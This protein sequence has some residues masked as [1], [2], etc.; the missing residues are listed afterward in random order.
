MTATPTSARGQA[1]PGAPR[2]RYQ[3][4]A[5]LLDPPGRAWRRAPARWAKERAGLELWSAQRRIIES[6]RDHTQTAVHSCHEVGK[7]F[8]AAATTCWWIDTHP[9]GEAFVVTT[10]PSDK[11]VKAILWREINK[12]HAR[13][14]LP[15]RT[16]LDEWYVGKEMV[17]FGRKPADHDPTAFQGLHARYVLVILDEACGIPKE[18]WDAASTLGANKYGR[19]LAIGNPDDPHGEFATNCRPN[20]GWNVIHVGYEDTPNF[21]GEPISES[22]SEMLISREWV[23]GRAEKWGRESAIFTSKCRGLFPKDSEFGVVPYSWAVACQGLELPYGEPREGGIDVG[24]GGDRTVIRERRGLRAGRVET[25]LDNDPMRTVGRLVEKINEW[26]LKRVKVDSIGVGW[27]VYGRLW[28]LSSVHNP[29]GE[30]THNAE[31]VA[32]NFGEAADEPDRFLN[33]RAEVWWTVGRE[34][35]RLR[36]WDLSEVDDDT[37]AE[38]TNPAYEILDS[39]GKV[40]IEKKEEVIKRMGRS[41]DGADALLLAFVETSFEAIIGDTDAMNVD[42]TR[43][44]NP[45]WGIGV[46]VTELGRDIGLATDGFGAIWAR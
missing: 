34:N 10:A 2:S 18:L 45:D 11:Q 26:G 28:E 27:G 13:L 39:K 40:K 21:T 31:V 38:L 15:G 7:S 42:L 46:E 3:V 5:D 41:P 25:F 4:A 43:E 24:A 37:I 12:L 23:E 9:L 32:V 44:V 22:L 14:G 17:A 30:C 20:S 6:V 19:T 29:L 1:A 16:N 8:I 33:K 36:R 35:S